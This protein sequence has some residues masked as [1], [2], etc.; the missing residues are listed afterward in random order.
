MASLY[1]DGLAASTVK[2]YLAAVRH[3]QI[4]LGMGDPKMS[5]MP[6]LEY[7]VKGARKL[8]KPAQAR[9]RLPITPSILKAL[10]GVWSKHRNV[11]DAAMLWGASCMC[12][13]GFLR[14]GEVTAPSETGY[15]PDLHLSFGDVRVD[16]YVQPKYIEVHLKASKTDPFRKGVTVYIGATNSDICPVAAVLSY[17]VRR[18]SDKGPLFMFSDKRLLTRDRFVKSLREGLREAGIKEDNYAGHSF[19]I[20]AATTAA[21]CGLPDSLIQ[22]LGRWQSS[23][24]TVYIRTPVQTFCEVS[25]R[26]AKC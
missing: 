13:F 23:A 22:T 9:K 20:G 8:A 5:D 3:T 21:I 12:F 1:Q 26:L 19:R 25:N 24:Y 16:N 10:K 7:V 17:L 14:S 2:C 11:F 18:G 6:R 4:S 15:D